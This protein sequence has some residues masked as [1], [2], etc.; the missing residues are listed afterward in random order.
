MGTKGPIT[1]H[2]N[3]KRPI[4]KRSKTKRQITKRPKT[5][6]QITKRLKQNAQNKCPITKRPK[7][8][9]A[10]YASKAAFEVEKLRTIKKRNSYIQMAARVEENI[11]SKQYAIRC[12]FLLDEEEL[13]I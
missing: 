6:R 5:K 2:S 1:K 12:L 4:T 7:T 11:E 3:T 9:R 13:K 8:K 10:I